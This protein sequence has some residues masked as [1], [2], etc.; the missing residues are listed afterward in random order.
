[1]MSKV[2]L[3][4]GCSS[5]IGREMAERLSK[6]GYI[7]VATARNL[8]DMENLNVALKLSLDIT[9]NESIS[10]AVNKVIQNFGKIDVLIN[11]A[12][13][14]FRSIVE[15]I[16]DNNIE[17]MFNVNVYGIIRMIRAVVPYMRKERSGRIINISSIAGKMVLP[18][19]GAYCA[20]KFA[21]E[22][23]SD[24]LRLE[25]SAFGIYVVVVEPGNIRTNFM[26]TVQN[27]S[28]RIISDSSSPYNELYKNYKTFN[29]NAR[30]NEPGPEVVSLVVQKAIEASR[31]KKRYMAGVPAFN[32]MMTHFGDGV[33]DYVVKS[34]FKIK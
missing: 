16:S 28:D 7:V 21:T 12:G 14:A 20:S 3:I 9:N 32:R 27:N 29:D 17:Q 2:I 15:E 30:T 1:M 26:K 33:K 4:T 11:N 13:Y 24:A 18:V 25:L 6:N 5:G 10:A 23:L 8:N 34:L 22:A 19:S 31:P